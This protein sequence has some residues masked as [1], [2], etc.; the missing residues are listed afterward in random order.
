MTTQETREALKFTRMCKYW[1]SGRCFNGMACPFAHSE[2]ELCPKPSLQ[3]TGLCYQ[4]ANTGRCSKGQACN[5]AHGW[6]EL[7]SVETKKAP[8]PQLS[9]VSEASPCAQTTRLG[10]ELLMQFTMVDRLRQLEEML[11]KTSLDIARVQMA[12]PR[13]HSLHA[14]PNNRSDP[15]GSRESQRF[16]VMSQSGPRSFWL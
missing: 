13:G 1:D 10:E 8:V 4:F 14:L 6:H 3:A 7:R 16:H 11:T 5:F 15:Q 9:Q 12:S 2:S